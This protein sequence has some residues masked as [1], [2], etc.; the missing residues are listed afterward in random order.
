MDMIYEMIRELMSGYFFE[1][2]DF[3]KVRTLA[4]EKRWTGRKSA[5]TWESVVLVSSAREFGVTASGYGYQNDRA[6]FG[7][8]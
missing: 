3:T 5:F 4:T 7:R 6:T 2:H 1:A 8:C